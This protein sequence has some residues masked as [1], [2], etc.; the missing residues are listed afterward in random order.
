MTK[1]NNV[2]QEWMVR[3]LKQFGNCAVEASLTPKRKEAYINGFKEC[4]FDV[5]IDK[6]NIIWLKKEIA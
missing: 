5:R 3:N 2:I 6:Q 1:E 4:G